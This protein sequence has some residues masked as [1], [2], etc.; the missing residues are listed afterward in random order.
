MI[1]RSRDPRFQRLNKV[2]H[3]V[4]LLRETG[5]KSTAWQHARVQTL[6][7]LHTLMDSCQAESQQELSHSPDESGEY[8]GA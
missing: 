7:R 2:L 4:I 8:T 6:W 3:R 5:P 1:Y